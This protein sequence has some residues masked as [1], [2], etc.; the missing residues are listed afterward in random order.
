MRLSYGRLVGFNFCYRFNFMCRLLG[1]LFSFVFFSSF[2]FVCSFSF[3]SVFFCDNFAGV[4]MSGFVAVQVLFSMMLMF[5]LFGCCFGFVSSFHVFVGVFFFSFRNRLCFMRM[6]FNRS[7]FMMLMSGFNFM[8]DLFG[9]VF[10]WS[11]V[12]MDMLFS[13]HAI[14]MMICN[15]MFVCMFSF[16]YAVFLVQCARK[17]VH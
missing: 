9:M 17:L 14:F 11:A 2:S 3:V 13:G 12:F 4:L 7:F 8:N 6:F 1:S 15:L 5:V 16:G 10:R